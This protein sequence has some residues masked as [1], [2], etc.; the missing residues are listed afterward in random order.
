MSPP[1]IYDE[2]GDGE[3]RGSGRSLFLRVCESE[4]G[5]WRVGVVPV[6]GE[7]KKEEVRG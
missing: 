2:G 7:G 4:E 3:L 5:K 6:P 1:M